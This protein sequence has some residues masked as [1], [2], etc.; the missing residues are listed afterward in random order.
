MR[1]HTG[2]VIIAHGSR[3]DEANQ[4]VMYIGKALREQ[5][6]YKV[7]EVGYLELAR[8]DVLTAIDTCV[9]KGANHVI[10]IPFFLLA[11]T[12]VQE[13]LP[14]L[15]EQARAKHPDVIIQMGR[16]LGFHQQLVEI[17]LDRITDAKEG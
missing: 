11:G 5:G 12:H 2:I 1:L 3:S 15:M 7:V 16:H 4:D 13:D 8:P 14:A 9:S 10:V 6:Y 17:I